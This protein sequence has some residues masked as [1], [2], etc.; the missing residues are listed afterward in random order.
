MPGNTDINEGGQ[1]LPDIHEVMFQ[2]VLADT[3]GL[4]ISP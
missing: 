3:E 2:V 4:G 1:I